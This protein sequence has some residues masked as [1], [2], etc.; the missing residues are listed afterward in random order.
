MKPKIGLWIFTGLLALGLYLVGCA[1]PPPSATIVPLLTTPPP[2]TGNTHTQAVP[3]PTFTP[4]AC[5]GWHCTLHGVVYAGEAVLGNELGGVMVSLS[6][7]SYC[8]PTMGE[9]EAVTG[10]D[11]A[12]TFEVYLHDTD[13]FHF[14]VEIDGYQTWEYSFG[15]FDCLY[16]SCPPLEVVLRPEK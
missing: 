16:C 4:T 13:S 11:G 12:F 15:G 1:S 10:E 7:F 2:Q 9:H 3:S 8:S 5:T 14:E 6:H